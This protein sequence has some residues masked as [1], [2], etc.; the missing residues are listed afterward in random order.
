MKFFYTA[1]EK[2]IEM[3]I[4]YGADVNRADDDGNN[5]LYWSLWGGKVANKIQQNPAQYITTISLNL[6]ELLR[7]IPKRGTNGNVQKLLIE[8][9]ANVNQLNK[10]GS[11]ALHEAAFFG[12][13]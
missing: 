9:G 11:T 7:V 4:A 6:G 1:N 13:S 12:N 5:A 2:I 8:N 3:L 10:W